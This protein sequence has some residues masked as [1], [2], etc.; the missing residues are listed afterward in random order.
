[1]WPREICI[2]SPFLAWAL[3]VFNLAIFASY[4]SIPLSIYRIHRTVGPSMPEPYLLHVCK[5]FIV[6][7]GI[8]HLVG[9]LVV[10]FLLFRFETLAMGFTAFV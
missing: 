6:F 1:M 9:A 10:F 7:C 3:V 5:A 8:S 2:A 4:V